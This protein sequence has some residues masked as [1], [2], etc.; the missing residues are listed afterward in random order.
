MVGCVNKL[1]NVLVFKSR[2]V[3]RS[4]LLDVMPSIDNEMCT[5]C[6]L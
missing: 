4:F 1:S 2:H 6:P 5:Y 3:A